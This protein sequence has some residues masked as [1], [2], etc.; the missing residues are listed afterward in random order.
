MYYLNENKFTKRALLHQMGGFTALAG[1]YSLMPIMEADAAVN[2]CNNLRYI[3]WF[4]QTMPKKNISDEI[5]P[6]EGEFKASGAFEI[7][8]QKK[9]K[10]THFSG[11]YNGAGND[12]KNSSLHAKGITGMITGQIIEGEK[13][14][15]NKSLSALF[16]K[17]NHMSLDVY[18]ADE[19]NK[20]FGKLPLFALNL[21]TEQ[22]WTP[23]NLQNTYSIQNG[24]FRPTYKSPKDAFGILDKFTNK[25]S[26]IDQS[27]MMGMT[28][29]N[30]THGSQLSALDYSLY[31]MN[32]LK[33]KI[34]HEDYQR[35]GDHIQTLNELKDQVSAQSNISNNASI[36]VGG[37][38]TCNLPSVSD[39]NISQ[40]KH[41]APSKSQKFAELD[42]GARVDRTITDAYYDTYIK[43]I[44]AAFNCNMTR[45]ATTYFGAW[46]FNY[47]FLGS[48]YYYHDATHTG[49]EQKFVQDVLEY[50]AKKFVQ[51]LNELEKF[52]DPSGATLLDNTIVHWWSEHGQN[53]D[54]DNAF[55]IIAGNGDHFKLGHS[56]HLKDKVTQNSLLTSIANA[57]CLDLNNFGDDKYHMGPLPEEVLA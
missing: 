14:G 31:I 45:V 27:Q 33:A 35:L 55:N 32:K 43:L 52:K 11:L 39:L 48:K 12:V 57:M 36:G 29:T 53:H 50:R 28:V 18:L 3:S 9:D 17:D 37:G 40:P 34:S 4:L 22:H 24:K 47:N 30:S 2:D 16:L 20:K 6:K 21:R 49:S 56:F 38:S 15:L 13:N 54:Y 19:L 46:N 23:V 1:L 5:R 8:N 25:S 51:L 26:S 41:K 7:L 10:M 42:D 44:A